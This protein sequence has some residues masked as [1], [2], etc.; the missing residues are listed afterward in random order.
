MSKDYEIFKGKKLSDLFQEIHQNSEVKRVQIDSMLSHL[1]SM[2]S[3]PDDAVQLVPVIKDYM[4]VAVKN[5]EQLIKIA[6]IVGRILQAEMKG[7]NDEGILT[8]MEKEQL[9]QALEDEVSSIQ[10][11]SDK[12]KNQKKSVDSKM[13]KYDKN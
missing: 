4:E 3:N 9:M 1:T 7:V 8:D 2:I 11:E 5:D 13:S 10:L 6:G 12:I